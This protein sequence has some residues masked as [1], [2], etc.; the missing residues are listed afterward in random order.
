MR[1][2]HLP[3]EAQ[4]TLHDCALSVSSQEFAHNIKLPFCSLSQFAP[5]LSMF[6]FCFPNKWPSRVRGGIS[7]HTDAS[8]KPPYRLGPALL[9]SAHNSDLSNPV[10]WR[11]S[12]PACPHFK[13]KW[14]NS[15]YLKVKVGNL[16][17]SLKKKTKLQLGSP[18]ENVS[19][20]YML[21]DFGAFRPWSPGRGG[22]S[23]FPD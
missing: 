11:F 18:C 2:L 23:V 16:T 8:T 3:Q 17:D 20:L 14:C 6:S 5:N 15:T 4:S 19:Q 7:F 1:A 21:A 13:V 12:W 10:I 22:M 9:A